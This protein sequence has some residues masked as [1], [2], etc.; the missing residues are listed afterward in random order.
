MSRVLIC[1]D[2]EFDW[3]TQQETVRQEIIKILTSAPVLAI[4]DPSLPTEVHTDASSLGYG[5]VLQQ[6]HKDGNRRVVAY[7]RRVTKGAELKYYSY[8]LETMAVVKALKHF[9]HLIGIQFQVV[10]DCNGF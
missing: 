1:K 3:G 7:C 6:V 4:F 9:R 2:V 8:E 5:A 10:T